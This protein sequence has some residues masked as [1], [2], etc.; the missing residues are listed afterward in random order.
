MRDGPDRVFE[1]PRKAAAVKR[2]AACGSIP[3]MTKRFAK[4]WIPALFLAALATAL[5]VFA[6]ALPFW[7]VLRAP[8][9]APDL[10]NPGPWRRA[11]DWALRGPPCLGHDELLR[12]LL[13]PLWNHELGFALDAALQA[14]ALAAYLRFFGLPVS[15][16]C[17]G[18]FAL[19]FAGYNFTLFNAGHRGYANSMPYAVLLFAIVESALRRPAW[20]QAVLGAVCAVCAVSSQP[21]VAAFV[22]LLSVGYAAFRLVSLA[23]AEGCRAYFA[24]RA[25]GFVLCV[26]VGAASLAVFGGSTAR[27]VFGDVLRGR[28]AQIAGASSSPAPSAEGGAAAEE[29]EAAARDRWIFATNWSLPPED[30]LEFVAPDVRGR[31]TGNPAAP[32]WGRLG[33]SHEWSVERPAGFA[34]FRQHALYVG[35][36]VAAIALFALLCAALD[37]ASPHRGVVFFWGVALC[38]SVLLALGRHGFL[39]RAFY[40]L[41]MMDKVR[42]PVKFVHLAEIAFASLFAFGLARLSDL[43]RAASPVS[44]SDPGPRRAAKAGAFA[45]LGIGAALAVASALPPRVPPFVPEAAAAAGWAAALRRGAFLFALSAAAV[46][47][48]AWSAGGAR[49][50]AAVALAPALAAVAALDLATVA[51]RYVAVDDLSVRDDPSAAADALLASGPPDGKSWSYVLLARQALPPTALTSLGGALD[52]AGF[53]QGDVL[54]GDAPDYLRAI[55]WNAFGP[56]LARRWR[57]WGV[58]GAFAT[59]DAARGLAEAGMADVVAL[60]DFSSRGVPATAA[61]PRRPRFALVA[62]RGIPP[63]VGVWH[64]WRVVPDDSPRAA[65]GVLAEKDFDDRRSLAVFSP[66][67]V[68][69]PE[70]TGSAPEPARWVEPP[71]TTDG[72]RA[73]IVAE[74]RESGLLFVR[75]NRLRGFWPHLG[76]R[77]AGR[78]AP[79]LRANG[80]FLAVPVPAGKTE[81]EIFPDVPIRVFAAAAAG[82][83]L[84]LVALAAWTKR[85]TEV[86]QHG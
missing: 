63:S 3:R 26:L 74:P 42:A 56:D 20:P 70:K 62:P 39:Y 41:P 16:C 25:R 78:P 76:A 77:V 60:L 21:D 9:A 57:F 28:E 64:D 33:R 40:A 82:W 43:A 46:S 12:I 51:A 13:P 72:R 4:W 55:A 79:V 36:V 27:H 11:A 45:L 8:D 85:V 22:L 24:P 35:A 17:G 7:A 14:V 58:A 73:V 86:S 69:L 19:A 34:N 38:L 32:Y 65:I 49:R 1:P 47:A 53:M 48:A 61:D 80:A 52:A 84:A 59:P 5:C 37:P 29:S 30:V 67:G 66:E 83:V 23:R 18:G 68:T 10:S 31:D 15:A 71:S 44:P 75:D 6:P 54:A 50:V 81:V 2:G